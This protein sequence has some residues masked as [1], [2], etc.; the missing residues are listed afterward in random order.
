MMLKAIYNESKERG[1]MADK[2]LVA[3]A[4]GCGST[5]EI[6]EAIGKALRA[7][8]LDADVRPAKEVTDVSAYRAVVVGSAVRA[9]KPLPDAVRW[10]QRNQPALKGMSV[11][12]FIGCL[13]ACEG[14]EKNA[15]LMEKYL[16]PLCALVP[17]VDKGFFAGAVD[18]HKLPLPLGLI[19]KAMKAPEGDFRDW[20]A[21]DAWAQGL[22]AKFHLD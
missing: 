3:Y 11:A 2:V 17:P 4:S 10:V 5:G 20:A 14:T 19:L 8:G 12:Y 18:Y 22:P 16:D 1:K 6:A 21:I 13:A 15:P 9:G 7:H